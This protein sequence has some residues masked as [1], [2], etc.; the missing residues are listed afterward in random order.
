M[1]DVHPDT[2]P[3]VAG[4]GHADR[5]GL[6]HTR[7]LPNQSPRSCAPSHYTCDATILAFYVPF[8]PA[9]LLL[10]QNFDFGVTM[11]GPSEW[12]LA[13]VAA[14]FLLLAAVVYK[15]RQDARNADRERAEAARRHAVALIEAQ[16]RAAAAGRRADATFAAWI[17]STEVMRVGERDA[18]F[19]PH[20]RSRGVRRRAGQPTRRRAGRHEDWLEHSVRLASEGVELL[21]TF[22]FER[23]V[24]GRV[25]QHERER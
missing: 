25:A 1:P 12:Q 15:W 17:R 3:K 8:R 21:A 22:L 18:A 4:L 19:A 14:T 10:L 11:W 20:L 7:S 6:R 5:R 16:A 2:K 23:F 9:L 24:G 13:V